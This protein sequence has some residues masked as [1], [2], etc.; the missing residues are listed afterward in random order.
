MTRGQHLHFDCASGAA[1]DMI[2]GALIDLGVP[3]DVIGNALDAIGAGRHRLA[4]TKIVTSA[5]VV[6]S[7]G[8]SVL[9]KMKTA[10]AITPAGPVTFT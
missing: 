4:I 10:S 8:R 9:L 5:M 3:L 6:S 1:G 7:S 2:L